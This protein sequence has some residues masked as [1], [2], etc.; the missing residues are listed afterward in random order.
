MTES[1]AWKSAR[2]GEL[3]TSCSTVLVCGVLPFDS[4]GEKFERYVFLGW[5]D[6]TDGLWY[7]GNGVAV[8]SRSLIEFWADIPK[9]PMN[10]R[11]D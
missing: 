3:P 7:M 10:E 5:H 9:G 11:N 6:D 8:P 1:I 2:D 4:W